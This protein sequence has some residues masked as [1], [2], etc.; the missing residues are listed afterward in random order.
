M[1]GKGSDRRP[2][3][4]YEK[5]YDQINWHDDEE[6]KEEDNADLSSATRSSVLDRTRKREKIGVNP[7]ETPVFQG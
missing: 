5:H 2:G 7:P 6:D 3:S 4:N 1:N